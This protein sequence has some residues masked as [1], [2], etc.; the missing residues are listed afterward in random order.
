MQ[1]VSLAS[2]KEDNP[3][4]RGFHKDL[5]TLTACLL[6]MPETLTSSAKLAQR[7]IGSLQKTQSN[8]S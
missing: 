2:Y 1:K 3:V 6:K 7:Q 5:E 8:R 4:Y